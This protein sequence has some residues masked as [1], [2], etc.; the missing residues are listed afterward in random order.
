MKLYIISHTK[1][2][3]YANSEAEEA[4]FNGVMNCIT[5][6]SNWT[7]ALQ[8]AV[9]AFGEYN[10]QDLEEQFSPSYGSL[11]EIDTKLKDWPSVNVGDKMLVVSPSMD[12]FY[13]IQRV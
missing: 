8:I 5:K 2:K 4:A 12:E 6:V 11:Q 9:M 10:Q 1:Q 3:H 7:G 13:Y